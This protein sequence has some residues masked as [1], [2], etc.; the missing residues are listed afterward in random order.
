MNVFYLNL[1]L[2][3]T[4]C[5]SYSIPEDWVVVDSCDVHVDLAYYGKNNFTGTQLPGYKANK[6]YMHKMLA[7]ILEI[8]NQEFQKMGYKL[9]I[10]DAYR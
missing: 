5:N 4:L 8:K 3:L 10:V 9:R 1:L 2:L 7:K 6:A